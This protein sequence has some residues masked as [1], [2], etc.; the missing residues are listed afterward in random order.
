MRL[1]KQMINASLK[2]YLVFTVIAL[3][4]INNNSFF[5]KS[6]REKTYP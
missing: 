6:A 5:A 4:F 2:K 3:V 1:I